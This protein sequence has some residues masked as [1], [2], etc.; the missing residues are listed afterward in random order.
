MLIRATGGNA[1]KHLIGDCSLTE[2]PIPSITLTP[3]EAGHTLLDIGCNWGRWT[4]LPQEKAFLWSGSI[5]P[6][7]AVMAARRIAEELNLDIKYLVA[8]GR[9]HFANVSSRWLI[10]T[11]SLQHLSKDDARKTIS[12]ISRVLEPRGVAKI[13]MANRWVFAAFSIRRGESFAS[14]GI[15]KCDIGR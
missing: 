8:D 3:L 15:S 5:H 9:F 2:Y 12:E 1:Y 4:L 11:A 13:Q 10:R 7:G 14:R 6:W